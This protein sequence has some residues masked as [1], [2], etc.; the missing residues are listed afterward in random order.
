MVYTQSD[1][2][3]DEL[4]I[5]IGIIDCYLDLIESEDDR[6]AASA[7]DTLCTLL[8]HSEKNREAG[9]PNKIAEYV[10]L[11]GFD[12]VLESLQYSES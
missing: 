6:I 1:K 7:I 12:K 8:H 5:K 3:L 2:D 11:Q 10:Q 4:Y 9:G